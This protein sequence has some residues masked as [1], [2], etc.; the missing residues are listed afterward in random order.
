MLHRPLPPTVSRRPSLLITNELARLDCSPQF[1]CTNENSTPVRGT[2][3]MRVILLLA[4]AGCCGLLGV[5]RAAAQ[6]AFAPHCA[7]GTIVESRPDDNP[8]KCQRTA[9]GERSCPISGKLCVRYY[10]IRT[11]I[12]GPGVIC[13]NQI[14]TRCVRKNGNVDSCADLWEVCNWK[15]IWKVCGSDN[16]DTGN[17]IDCFSEPPTIKP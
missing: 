8:S 12:A 10:R 14:V 3:T 13:T 16:A 5:E 15:K 1:D 7:P 2:K 17:S 9:A 11:E 4:L 6:A